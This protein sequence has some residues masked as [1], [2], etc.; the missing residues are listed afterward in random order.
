[1]KEHSMM[2]LTLALFAA[3]PGQD[4]PKAEIGWKLK[5]GDKFRCE[6]GLTQSGTM[7]DVVFKSILFFNLGLEIGD[8]GKDG[9]VEAKATYERIR[10]TL[11]SH[12]DKD[13]IL[14]SDREE[15]R[16]IDPDKR[17]VL[18]LKGRTISLMFG[19][20]GLSRV[21]GLGDAFREAYKSIGQTD[22]KV[23]AKSEQLAIA[24]EQVL[25]INFPGAPDS[26]VSAG[27]GW[28][29]SLSF[30][31]M[32]LRG[33]TIK[34]LAKVKSLEK[35]RAIVDH[36]LT[37]EL[38]TE[39]RAGIEEV[40]GEGTT[41][42]DLERGLPVSHEIVIKVRGKEIDQKRFEEHRFTLKLEP[43]EKK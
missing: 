8:T 4:P 1:M 14:D 6:A 42:W 38:A 17:V 26:A 34:D 36:K 2:L 31:R 28:P 18:H 15:D 40:T 20:K 35:G 21:S 7:G 5:K 29:E 39:R 23:S 22:N 9:L 30:E 19:S 11:S 41:L 32:S 13:R 12:N 16:S 25:K 10:F 43:R 27:E 24:L 3:I 33:A 37:I